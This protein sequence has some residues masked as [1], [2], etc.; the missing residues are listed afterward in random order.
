MRQLLLHVGN[1]IV[2]LTIWLAVAIYFHSLGDP[3]RLI[4]EA[5]IPGILWCLTA[6][7]LRRWLR[8]R[9]LLPLLESERSDNLSD[10]EK[11]AFRNLTN[12]P[13]G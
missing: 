12:K 6:L 9:R 2:W 13:R 3:P 4:G 11:E 7:A 10:G 1:A 5:I 8:R